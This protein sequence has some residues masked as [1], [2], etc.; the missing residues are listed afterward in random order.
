MSV[1]VAVFASGG[2]T[3]L[4]ALLDH[5]QD[6]G[7]HAHIALVLSDRADAGALDRAAAA[8]VPGRVVQVSGRAEEEI[9]AETLRALEDAGVGLVAL[10]GYLRL[11]PGVVVRRYTGRMVNIHP[12]L[13]PA[14]G[15]KGMYGANVHRAVLAAGATV[16]GP[17]VHLVDERYD[18]GRILAQWP[19]PVLPG[20]TPA[21][22]GAR[23]LRAEHALYPSVVE[24][25]AARLAE[26]DDPDRTGDA[27]ADALRK[28][29]GVE[30]VF[31]WS[32]G[33]ETD[34]SGIR[35][36]LGMD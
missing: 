19:V 30:G 23:V 1:A 12:A 21:I 8:G 25:L 18:E 36:M 32:E 13:L 17:T 10:A 33:D 7:R 15:G 16:S 3:N 29:P 22:L 6:P 11:M 26:S 24:W 31:R 4:Q 20:D 34:G 9:A 28:R 27:V 35:R 2:G 14:F 5:F